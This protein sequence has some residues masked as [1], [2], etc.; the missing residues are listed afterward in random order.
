MATAT[1]DDWK[2][3]LED[4]VAARS[5]ICAVDGTAGTGEADEEGVAGTAVIVPM[6]A[7]RQPSGPLEARDCGKGQESYGGSG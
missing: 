6:T 5:A 1:R 7:R 3:G 4:V 2:A